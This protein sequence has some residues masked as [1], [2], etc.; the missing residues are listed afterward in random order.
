MF[1]TEAQREIRSAFLGGFVGQLVAGLIWALSVCR[2]HLGRTSF[3]NGYTVFRKHVA[4]PADPTH[5]AVDGPSSQTQRPKHLG[6]TGDPNSVHSSDWVYSRWRRNTL[7]AELVLSSQHGSGGRSLLAVHLSIWNAA[8]WRFSWSTD[9]RGRR[10]WSLRAGYIQSGR[11]AERGP[12]DHIRVRWAK[13]CVERGK[14][15]EPSDRSSG[16]DVV[17]RAE[18]RPTPRAVDGWE[19]AAWGVVMPIGWRTLMPTCWPIRTTARRA[20]SP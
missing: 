20:S 17:C 15:G 5:L 12:A 1:I 18:T 4:V 13:C 8:V 2:Q 3:R 19:S 11:L 9:C 16:I 10:D 14:P 6:T 7:S